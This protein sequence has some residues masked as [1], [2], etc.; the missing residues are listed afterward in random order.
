[1]G[2]IPIVQKIHLGTVE[3]EK[4]LHLGPLGNECGTL[5]TELHAPYM[6]LTVLKTQQTKAKTIGAEFRIL[7]LFFCVKSATNL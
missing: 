7:W 3:D 5:L 2:N 6:R 4:F 1:M